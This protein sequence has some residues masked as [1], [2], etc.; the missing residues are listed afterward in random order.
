MVL[1]CIVMLGRPTARS[2]LLKWGSAKS[3][4]AT[5]LP[6]A[7]PAPGET[8]LTGIGDGCLPG[9][10]MAWKEGLRVTTSSREVEEPVSAR[11]GR[12]SDPEL[13]PRRRPSYEREREPA[14]A[15]RGPRERGDRDWDEETE[16]REYDRPR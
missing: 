10:S 4:S 2:G 12:R 6:L 7:A 1:T 14:S 15:R 11:G 9:V 16:A 8:T 13:Q 3:R 5:L